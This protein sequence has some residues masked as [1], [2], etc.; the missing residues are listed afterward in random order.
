[1]AGL[2]GSGPETEP[3]FR[4]DN[5]PRQPLRAATGK[6]NIIANR[7]V[8]F[9]SVDVC[10]DPAAKDGEPIQQPLV[11]LVLIIPPDS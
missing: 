1:M 10:A 5:R 2:Q 7:S 4:L 9:F 8:R 3:T 11:P 6:G